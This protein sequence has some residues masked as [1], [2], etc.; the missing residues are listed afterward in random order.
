[1]SLSL[2]N[3]SK[4][5]K[6]QEVAS[7]YGF[8]P[9]DAPKCSRDDKKNAK[10]LQE[11]DIHDHDK[12]MDQKISLLRHYIEEKLT[13]LPRP[14]MVSYRTTAPRSRTEELHLDIIG[15]NKSI[16]EALILRAAT[17]ILAEEGHKNLCVHLNSF[18]DRDSYT[19][20]EQELNTF[21]RKNTGS[22]DA[23][24]QQALRTNNFALFT[25]DCENCYE[26]RQIAPKPI[27]FLDD[28]SRQ[29]FKE[30][31]EYIDTFDIPYQINESLIGNKHYG[32]ETL[33]EIRTNGTAPQTLAHGL[34]Y[35]T[36]IKK[37][38]YR[39]DMPAIGLTLSYAPRKRKKP[40]Q[41][42]LK[43]L[44]ARKFYFVHLGFEAKVKSFHVIENLRRA[45]IPV[46]HSLTKNKCEGQM[47]L[48]KRINPEYLIIMGIKEAL[49][50]SVIIRNTD[51][52]TQYVV[53][54]NELV[55]FIR[56]IA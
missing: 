44:A 46:H 56:K 15:N 51:T 9:I 55:P 11:T 43:N 29:H 12:Y 3:L 45:Q 23:K 24:H 17:A 33:F 25:C 20:F 31:L 19:I 32:G 48:A 13:H 1:M 26:L 38:G 27:N 41:K 40:T 39:R 10:P 5:R 18:G 21:N 52:H 30:V 2:Q 50:N 4:I 42:S 54:M 47:T 28:T 22:L 49:E 53:P 7:Y 14:T 34:R 6:A 35:N 16:A 36:L 8:N 37:M